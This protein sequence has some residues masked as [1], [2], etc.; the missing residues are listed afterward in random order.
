MLRY[1][2]NGGLLLFGLLL[3][4]L[5]RRL[6]LA[7]MLKQLGVTLYVRGNLAQGRLVAR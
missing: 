5:L 2:D 3:I 7:I 4:M 6:E 1:Y